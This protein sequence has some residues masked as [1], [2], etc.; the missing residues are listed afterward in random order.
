MCSFSELHQA[1]VEAMR[2]GPEQRKTKCT[3]K[4]GIGADAM[5]SDKTCEE[6]LMPRDHK[7]RVA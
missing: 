5:G 4:N 7:L 2:E 3:E 6:G 1:S